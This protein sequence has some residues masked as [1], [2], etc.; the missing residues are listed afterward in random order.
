MTTL[1]DRLDARPAPATA[2]ASTS[3]PP[4][5]RLRATMAAARVSFTWMGTQKTLNADQ[6]ASLD[7]LRT[8]SGFAG[9]RGGGGGGGAA[10]G[11][12]GAG[13]GGGGAAGGG[14]GAGAGIRTPLTPEQQAERTKQRAEQLKAFEEKAKAILSETQNIR[15]HQIA[16]QLAGPRAVLRAD[17]QA[18]LGLSADKVA[19]AKQLVADASKANGE[20]RQKINSQEIER[21]DGQAIIDKNNTALNNELIGL[22]D[23]AQSAKVKELGG[24]EFKAAPQQGR[25]GGGL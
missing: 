13:A 6:K 23:A 4:A 1:L 17:V 10:G 20:V 8:E 21:A 22:L 9:R 5:Q 16:I 24:A 3:T 25:G 2:G 11:G 15:L 12:G 19:K 7:K 18:A 14:G